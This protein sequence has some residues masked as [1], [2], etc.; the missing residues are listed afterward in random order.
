M[1]QSSSVLFSLQELS[2]MEEER[3][4]AQAE[5]SARQRA[6]AERALRQAEEKERGEQAA[7]ERAEAEARLR[8][9][10]QVREEVARVEAIRLAATDAARI[11]AEASARAEERERERRHELELARARATARAGG[12]L[13]TAVAAA[14]GAACALG[15]AA[16]A[17]GGRVMPREQARAA[18]ARAD[19]ASRDQTSD[20]LRA[21]LDAAGERAASLENELTITRAA[22]RR[23]Q[24][25]V[26][27]AKRQL[28]RA[29]R[30]RPPVTGGHAVRDDLPPLDLPTCPP[31]SLDPLCLH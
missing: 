6:E 23:L 8:A 9:E 12:A 5:A 24:S 2:R 17:Y 10:Q 26:D 28:T 31:G 16:A 22:N 27:D 7:R 14:V 25:D 19:L 20:Q 29:Y 18:Q 15:A 13:R 30:A 4:R 1:S 21:K 11:S 3:V